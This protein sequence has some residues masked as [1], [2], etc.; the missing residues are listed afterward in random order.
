MAVPLAD[1]ATT[2]NTARA[3]REIGVAG[4]GDIGRATSG[5]RV[6]AAGLPRHR[7]YGGTSCPYITNA[8]ASSTAP[9]C[10]VTP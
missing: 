6:S 2:I 3:S 10:S 8:S 7:V 9:S 1:I 5:S 4:D